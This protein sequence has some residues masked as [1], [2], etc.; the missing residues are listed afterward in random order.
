ML[1]FWG[2]VGRQGKR[3]FFFK[4]WIGVFDYSPSANNQIVC[5]VVVGVCER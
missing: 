4:F 1:L 2:S 3:F 5:S